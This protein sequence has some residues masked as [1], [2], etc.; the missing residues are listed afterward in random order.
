MDIQR[1]KKTLD[2]MRMTLALFFLLFLVGCSESPEIE[3]GEYT[4]PDDVLISDAEIGQYGGSFILSDISTPLSFNFL[5]GLDLRTH[6]MLRKVNG[7]LLSYNPIEQ[8]YVPALAKS[9]EQDEAGLV[10][11][12]ELREGVRWSDGAPFTADDVIFTFDAISAQRKDEETGKMLPLYPTKYYTKL[13]Y[14]DSRLAYEKID[15]YTIRIT[16]PQIYAGLFYDLHDIL[17]LPKHVLAEAHAEKRLLEEWSVQTAIESPE[18]IVGLGPFVVESYLPSERLVLQ[19]NPHYWKADKEGQRLPYLDRMIYKYVA[20]STTTIMHVA[21]GQ[22]SGGGIGPSNVG[23]VREAQDV[24]GFKIYDRGPANMLTAIWL[25]L[26]PGK[27]EEGNLY[28]DSVTAS[29]LQDRRFRQ[30]MLYGFNRQGVVDASYFGG[31]AVVHSTITKPL[32]NWYNPNVRRYEYSPE[33]AMSLLTEA[34]FSKNEKGELFDASGNRVSITMILP[35]GGGWEELVLVF[36][37]NMA[38]LGI[39]ILLQPTEFA[40][41]ARQLEYTFDYEMMVLAWGYSS[42]AYDPSE[43]QSFFLSSGKDH[44]WH[45]KQIEPATEWEARIDELYKVQERTFDMETRYAAMHEIQ[46]ILAEELPVITMAAPNSYAAVKNHWRNLR[47]P[48]SGGFIWNI[49]EIWTERPDIP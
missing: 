22:V 8:T 26:N 48:D 29:W 37:E 14:G 45:P 28:V 23:W 41:M 49:E 7:S 11:T 6:S 34:G 3:R 25:N 27:D 10:Y 40:T 36:K 43:D 15:D 20:E 21:T 13:D 18:S 32:G 33:K 1:R 5:A 46:A 39:E 9:W 31:G 47:V 35:N 19:P 16:T 12:F 2:G 4:L 24:H 38:D 30:A 44:N 17:I 42:A